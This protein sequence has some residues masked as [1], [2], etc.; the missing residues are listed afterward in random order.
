MKF[1]E[2]VSAL[3]NFH[4]SLSLGPAVT[5]FLDDNT[6]FFLSEQQRNQLDEEDRASNLQK[7]FELLQKVTSDH[8]QGVEQE[9]YAKLQEE[10]QSLKMQQSRACRSC[11]TDEGIS[12]DSESPTSV[13]SLIQHLQEKEQ[14]I[15]LLEAQV[16]RVR[17]I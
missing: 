15:A 13:Q 10:L 5:S 16:I 4:C 6:F 1:Q 17:R 12:S 7:A 8:G 14:R 9:I 11:D 3:T 2:Q